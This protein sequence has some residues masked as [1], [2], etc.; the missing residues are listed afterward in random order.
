LPFSVNKLIFINIIFFTGLHW[1][2]SGKESTCQAGEVGLIPGS[3]RSP[4]EGNGNTFQYSCLG[5]KK[6]KKIFL[7]G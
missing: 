5:R 4:G 3:G 1:W 7:K 6:K 2:L